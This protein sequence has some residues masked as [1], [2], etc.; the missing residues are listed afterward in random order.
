MGAMK[1]AK[2]VISN[3]YTH[4]VRQDG[5]INHQ[6]MELDGSCRTLTV[7]AQYYDY[8]NQDAAFMLQNFAKAQALGNFLL[9]RRSLA[10]N[11]TSTDPR[12]GIPSGATEDDS[13][14]MVTSTATPR[15]TSLHFYAAAAEMYRAF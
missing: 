4:Y 9:F 10:L 14:E 7:L 12:F 5:M 13:A 2:G 15:R 3:Y 1:Y 11:Y 8:S 6:G